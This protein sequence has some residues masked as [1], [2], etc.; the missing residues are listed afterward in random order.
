MVTIVITA[1][2]VYVNNYIVYYY[3]E[4]RFLLKYLKHN[5]ECYSFY[6]LTKDL[7]PGCPLNLWF[8]VT[9]IKVTYLFVGRHFVRKKKTEESMKLFR[10][11]KCC[12]S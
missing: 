12:D 1:Y 2:L 7:L 9:Y 5:K 8:K 3:L 6:F 10:S 4:M 11:F